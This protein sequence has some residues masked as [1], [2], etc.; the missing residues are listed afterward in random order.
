MHR[1]FVA[2]RPPAAIRARLLAAM[3][4]LPGARWQSDDQLHLTLR[5]I[6]EVDPH[7]A[8]DIAAALGQIHAPALALRLGA[9]GH[10]AHRGR[11]EA[12]WVGVG[13]QAALERL[14][15]KV[16]RALVRAG[17]EPER[18]AFTPHITL[19]RFARSAPPL[20][21]LPAVD[22]GAADFTIAHFGLYE[23]TLGHEGA[24]YAEVARYPLDQAPD[25]ASSSWTSPR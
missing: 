17:L 21:A 25:A 22:L 13:P 15:D 24:R 5:F 19:A 16:D 2:L 11:P 4:G 10:F 18:R 8:D 6:G 12:L 20:A 23:S 9:P 14:H 7:R 3:G 1:L